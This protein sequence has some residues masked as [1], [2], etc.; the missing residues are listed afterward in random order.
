MNDTELRNIDLMNHMTVRRNT[1]AQPV[2]I[3][4]TRFSTLMWDDIQLVGLTPTR[5][6]QI[7]IPRCTSMTIQV[8]YLYTAVPLGAPWPIVTIR[9]GSVATNVPLTVLNGIELIPGDLLSFE[10]DDQE[11]DSEI[12]IDP[13]Q[14]WAFLNN[15]L[16]VRLHICYGV[17]Q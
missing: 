1:V 13:T 6:R 2:Q 10:A 8:S 16:Q 7:Q 5:I 9:D 3:R 11:I 4:G 15:I 14:Y 12:F 17:L